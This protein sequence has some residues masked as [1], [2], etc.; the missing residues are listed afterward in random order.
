MALREAQRGL[1]RLNR[2]FLERLIQSETV[3]GTTVLAVTQYISPGGSSA[4]YQ[5][6]PIKPS[7]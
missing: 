3:L 2:G 5:A 7:R 4:F 6:S 1:D